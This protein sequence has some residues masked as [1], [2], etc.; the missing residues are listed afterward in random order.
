MGFMGWL[1]MPPIQGVL[2]IGQKLAAEA[3]R[4]IYDAG[5]I[6]GRLQELEARY[7]MGEISEQ[8]YL[9]AEEI[10]LARLRVARE[11]AQL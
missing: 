3:E 9:E 7:D 6:R 8:E 10:L 1:L 4:E 11:H 5:A 2:W